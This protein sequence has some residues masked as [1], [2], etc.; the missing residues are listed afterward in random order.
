MTGAEMG[1]GNGVG[2]EAVGVPP[3]EGFEGHHHTFEWAVK[4]YE[5]DGARGGER[6]A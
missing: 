1:G 5:G 2:R 3:S 4:R 6:F